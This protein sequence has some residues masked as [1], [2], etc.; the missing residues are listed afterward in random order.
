V[1]LGLIFATQSPKGLHN[2]IPGNAATRFYGLFNAPVQI[3]AAR[4]VARAK[5]GDLPGISQLRGDELYV[6]PEGSSF[7]NVRTSLCLSHH[8]K[9]P[10]TQETFWLGLAGHRAV[11]VDVGRIGLWPPLGERDDAWVDQLQPCEERG[12][13]L[14]AAQVIGHRAALV[15][16]PV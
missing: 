6:A 13:L 16:L 14:R 4:E 2:R 15:V 11:A 7:T 8:P 5:G 1:S 9:S 12:D 3:E 10:L